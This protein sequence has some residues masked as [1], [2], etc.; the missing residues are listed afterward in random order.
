MRRPLAQQIKL[1]LAVALVLLFINSLVSYRNIRRLIFNE[2]QVSHSQ[3]VLAE[4]EATLSTVKDAETGQRGYLITED[5]NYLRPYQRAIAQISTSIDSLKRL[6]EDNP[7]QQRRILAL[8]QTIT[9]KLNELKQTIAVSRTQGF[10]AAQQLVRTNRGKRIM[11]YIRQQVAEMKNIEN[12]LLQQRAKESRAST[13]QTFVTFSI[14]TTLNLGLL[15]LVYHLFRLNHLQSQQEQETLERRVS[16][17][18]WQ[19]QEANDELE[20]FGYTVSHDLR[21]PLRGMQGFAE[22]LLEDYGDFLDDVGKDY[23][24]R[25]I[26]SAQR[27]EDLIQDLLAYSHLSR[28]ELSIKAINLTQLFSE[29]MKELQPEI[30]QKQAIVQIQS[31]LP[32]V[33]G[34][35]STLVQVITNLL[36][37][38]LKFV[39]DVPPQ[40]HIWAEV[41]EDTQT[42]F[43][44]NRHPWVR[45]WVAD[46]GI[47]IAPEHQNRIFR[48]FERLHG[49]ETYPGT[50][51]GL[52]IVR[53]G[54]ERMGGQVGV[55]SQLGKGSRFWIE[56]RSADDG[57]PHNFVSRR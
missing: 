42:E 51:V 29:V 41:K 5:E 13:E 53:K 23:T 36:A 27:L 21:A 35:R 19:L 25:I 12:R 46:N 31:P 14:A 18:T 24:Q 15:A 16:E 1:G 33:M 48:V 9:A 49:Q 32:E 56:L 45:L 44:S 20:A 37:N 26:I 34:H 47:G 55:E 22:A 3:Q 7:D 40:V 10:S 50:G 11:D 57:S 38:A 28:T 8:E 54:V 4:L 52:A 6:T 2:R 43:S 17:R 39:D 30:E